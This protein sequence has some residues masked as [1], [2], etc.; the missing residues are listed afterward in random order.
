MPQG[1]EMPVIATDL[2]NWL[3][4]HAVNALMAKT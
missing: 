4:T 2:D 1:A 3:G